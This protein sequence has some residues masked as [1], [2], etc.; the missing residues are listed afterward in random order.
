M[1]LAPA[2]LAALLAVFCFTGCLQ[3]EKIVKLNPDG[4]GTV[5]ET[6]IIPKTALATLQQMAG[7]GGKPLDIFDEAKLKQ[8]AS[9]MG[10]GV[11]FVSGQKL[12]SDAGEGFVATYA[13]TDINQLKLDQNPIEAMPGPTGQPGPNQ[14]K[15]PI[16]FHFTKGSPAELSITMPPPEFKPKPPQPAGAEDMAML[17][18]QKMLKDLKITFALEVPGTIGE[19]NAEYHE[20]SRVT[21]MEV[22]FNK[23]LDDPAKF[24]A[25]AT[26]N[27]Q[28]TAGSQGPHQRPRRRQDRDLTGSEDQVPVTFTPSLS[29]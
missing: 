21:F 25:L 18:M 27:P 23:V 9:Q 2:I 10:A 20:G 7:A 11:T 5:V 26:A 28:S 6:L 15:E 22:D 8:A 13:F 1:K 16:V 17:V 19:T 14:K 24:K 4:S 29:L 3:M 12:S